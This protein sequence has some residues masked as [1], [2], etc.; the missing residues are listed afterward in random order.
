MAGV[1]AQVAAAL[2]KLGESLDVSSR[3]ARMLVDV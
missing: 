1:L 2:A 3:Q